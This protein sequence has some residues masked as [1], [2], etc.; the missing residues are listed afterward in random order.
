LG[1]VKVTLS[2]LPTEYESPN[3][4]KFW[5][6][7][8]YTGF[9]VDR[10]IKY[11][12]PAGCE[13]IQSLRSSEFERHFPQR[14]HVVRNPD[15]FTDALRST[16]FYRLRDIQSHTVASQYS[17]KPWLS[18]RIERTPNLVFGELGALF[19]GSTSSSVLKQ[20]QDTVAGV[21]F[22]GSRGDRLVAGWQAED[23]PR[24]L[25]LSAFAQSSA[26]QTDY[27]EVAYRLFSRY[28]AATTARDFMD[29]V[30]A[31]QR[32]RETYMDPTYEPRRTGANANLIFVHAGP[33][34]PQNPVNPEAPMW[35]DAIQ[36]GLKHGTA[37]FV[38]ASDLSEDELVQLLSAIDPSLP[39][40]IT[41][42]TF[43]VRPTADGAYARHAY[44]HPSTRY[45]F[46]NGV[47][48][49]VIHTGADGAMY[50]LAAQNR[51]RLRVHE[52]PSVSDID[53]LLRLLAVRHGAG[54]ALL[55]GLEV[56]LYRA[57]VFPSSR[58]P[59]ART[60]VPLH[61][62]PGSDGNWELHLP[63]MYTASAYFD[64][65]MEPC[66]VPSDVDLF[67]SLRPQELINNYT[68]VGF[69]RTVSL[70][71]AS[72][73]QSLNGRT[74]RHR[75]QN[76]PVRGI[77]QWINIITRTFNF[78]KVTDWSTTH[79]NAMA[80]QYGYAPSMSVRSTEAGW[81]RSYWDDWVTPIYGNHYLELWAMEFMPTFQL[82]PF[83]DPELGSSHTMWPSDR[84]RPLMAR[85]SFTGQVLLGRDS[86]LFAPQA[87]KQSGGPQYSAQF[88]AAAGAG[89]E[90]RFAGATLDF[91]LMRMNEERVDRF[92]QAPA[93][94]PPIW[95]Q[96]ANQP[97]ADFLLPGTVNTWN[98]ESRVSYDWGV[99]LNAPP[100]GVSYS[101]QLDRW[102]EAANQ[103]P[104]QSLMVN[105]IHPTRDHR[106]LDNMLDYSTLILERGNTYSGLVLTPHL[107]PNYELDERF[108]PRAPKFQSIEVNIPEIG[109]AIKPPDG[110]RVAARKQGFGS[111]VAR[112]LQPDTAPP[113]ARQPTSPIL[114]FRPKNPEFIQDLP[115]L[116]P[117]TIL[118]DSNGMHLDAPAPSE[119]RQLDIYRD[120]KLP[121]DADYDI[122][123]EADRAQE[124]DRQFQE[125]LAFQAAQQA[126][127]RRDRQDR[128]ARIAERARAPRP[129]TRA[130]PAPR[131]RPAL[132]AYPPAV[133]G[134]IVRARESVR[135]AEKADRA[136]AQPPAPPV[137]A[138]PA[139]HHHQQQFVGRFPVK[140]A[141]TVIPNDA[142][143][144]AAQA[145]ALTQ[146]LALAAGGLASTGTTISHRNGQDTPS[147]HPAPRT[148]DNDGQDVYDPPEYWDEYESLGKPTENAN[149]TA[150]RQAESRTNSLNAAAY[151]AEVARSAEN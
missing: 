137:T 104:H 23:R 68:L 25:R 48:D 136:T 91:S 151:A 29:W 87:W 60:A 24:G 14:R 81:I 12:S 10:A 26:R 124:M 75:P 141:S 56:A 27:R 120:I 103:E 61:Q 65:F 7:T 67:L 41:D 114:Q 40:N 51:V 144:G 74:W 82:L 145:T 30:G 53:T 69:F 113:L 3:L 39:D 2:E 95:M 22:M 8:T 76:E 33:P 117:H 122:S 86:P 73:A 108:S 5:T 43:G 62:Y 6:P 80:I 52:P 115:P 112:P 37:Q 116:D 135:A 79:A 100:P 63:R 55:F 102:R 111:A 149:A 93:G 121:G 4:A 18:A 123:L 127:F 140:P 64:T 150:D 96:P 32:R 78:D 88:Y 58:L 15:T 89:N 110:T 28:I 70:N 9:S 38:D 118:I 31:A 36:R 21:R 71:W 131:R 129:T 16:L 133:R 128:D 97:F 143:A 92:R 44:R 90:W 126:K 148:T 34:D 94:Q 138:L 130:V 19:E 50:D 72:F 13:T 142:D 139:G 98:F 11:S 107:R 77:Q 66:H 105:Y 1:G 59:S 125:F 42:L 47:T 85:E 132:A 84:P 17:E 99:R 106:Q 146:S 49:I 45:T 134:A 46:A 54:P 109:P 57:A 20:G 83:Y 101:N 119:S 35:T 147:V